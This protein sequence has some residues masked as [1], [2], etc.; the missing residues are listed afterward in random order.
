MYFLIY[1]IRANNEIYPAS[2]DDAENKIQSDNPEFTKVIEIGS[3]YFDRWVI[4]LGL[5]MND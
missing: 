5:A 1:I 2:C 3:V 4:Y